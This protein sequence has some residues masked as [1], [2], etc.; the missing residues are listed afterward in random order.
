MADNIG[1][2]IFAATALSYLYTTGPPPQKDVTSTVPSQ[3]REV[4]LTRWRHDGTQPLSWTK[5]NGASFI[6]EA[7]SKVRPF[8]S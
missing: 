8:I 1:L 5:G 6:D 7:A 3:E 4:D 2:L